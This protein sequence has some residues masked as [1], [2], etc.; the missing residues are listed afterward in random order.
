M[1]HASGGQRVAALFAKISLVFLYVLN[2]ATFAGTFLFTLFPRNDALKLGNGWDNF[3]I[4]NIADGKI[5]P[6]QQI[7]NWGFLLIC[8]IALTLILTIIILSS[9]RHASYKLG[10]RN[11][12][13]KYITPMTVSSIILIAIALVNRPEL[14]TFGDNNSLLFVDGYKYINGSLSNYFDLS[15]ISIAWYIA[16]GI[17]VISGIGYVIS[18]IIFIIRILCTRTH[19]KKE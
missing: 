1:A 5:N 16:F 11:A 8:L 7:T 13:L 14:I 2:F 19:S 18:F 6:D 12:L 15:N 3:G 17:F 10:R 4:W 9:I